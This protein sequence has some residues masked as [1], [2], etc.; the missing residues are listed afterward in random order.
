MFMIL[1]INAL[2]LING[3]HFNFSIRF[4]DNSFYTNMEGYL[5]QFKR[6]KEIKAKFISNNLNKTITTEMFNFLP[7]DGISSRKNLKFYI[8][9]EAFFKIYKTKNKEFKIIL[10]AMLST[11]LFIKL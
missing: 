6:K 3:F 1:V 10:I 4:L 7:E 5:Y 2:K 9:D 11:C 8:N